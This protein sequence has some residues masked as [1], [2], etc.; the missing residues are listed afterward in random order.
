MYCIS[1]SYHHGL[2][3]CRLAIDVLQSTEIYF[4]FDL[5]GYFCSHHKPIFTSFIASDQ[6][7]P[8]LF[9]FTEHFCNRKGL[10]KSLFDFSSLY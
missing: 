5:C 2:K 4:P 6:M 7:W 3:E 8:F 1:L 10:R 9:G